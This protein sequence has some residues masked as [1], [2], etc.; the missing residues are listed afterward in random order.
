MKSIRFDAKIAENKIS[1]RQSSIKPDIESEF[2]T[3]GIRYYSTTCGRLFNADVYDK[4]FKV[5]QRTVKKKGYKGENACKR[6]AAI[7]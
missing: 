4:N 5:V 6:I 1:S 7:A 3:D 2:I